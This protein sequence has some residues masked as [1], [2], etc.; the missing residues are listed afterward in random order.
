[1]LQGNPD[2]GPQTLENLGKFENINGNLKV[3]ALTKVKYNLAECCDCVI[4]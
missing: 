2:I 4:R 1:M 3:I